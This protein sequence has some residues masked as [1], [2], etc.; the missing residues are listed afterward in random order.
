MFLPLYP[1]QQKFMSFLVKNITLCCSCNKY[2]KQFNKVYSRVEICNGGHSLWRFVHLTLEVNIWHH[3]ERWHI[4]T[5][6]NMVSDFHAMTYF[7]CLIVVQ[8]DII[9]LRNTKLIQFLSPL[10]II[11]FLCGSNEMKNKLCN[12][13]IDDY[14]R[15]S[16]CKLFED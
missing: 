6:I 10:C 2:N 3:A 8:N 1:Y 16:Y 12:N 14:C 7:Q 15:P 5:I 11:F 13:V 4:D 9:M